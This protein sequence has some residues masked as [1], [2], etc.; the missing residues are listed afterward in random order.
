MSDKLTDIE[1]DSVK[2]LWAKART[3]WLELQRVNQELITVAK[4]A[5]EATFKRTFTNLVGVAPTQVFIDWFNRLFD[6]YGQPNPDDVTHN[7]TRMV[8][9]WNPATRDFASVIQPKQDH[10]LVYAGEL[11]VHNA[12]FFASKLENWY[13]K[14]QDERTFAEFKTFFGGEIPAWYR[15]GCTTGSQG[16]YGGNAEA[17]DEESYAEAEQQSIDSLK[18]FSE[19]NANNARAF[20][21]MANGMMVLRFH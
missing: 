20:N 17:V 18:N 11:V 19:T 16:G 1:N 5:F 7:N 10:D 3:Q 2:I 9:E 12:G 15:A 6:V 14:P 4:T 8:A 13:K 21:T